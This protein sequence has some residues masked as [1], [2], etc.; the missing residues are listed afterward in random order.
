MGL[1]NIF[2]LLDVSR[3][4]DSYSSLL[5]HLLRHSSRLR[6]QVL[7]H[8]FGTAVP[9]LADALVA[10]RATLPDNAG[11]ADLLIVGHDAE[12]QRWELFIE[13]K[14]DAGEGS[15]QTARYRD[16][17]RKRT[18]G[19]AAG[20]YLTLDGHAA[21]ADEGVAALRH[22]DLGAWINAALVEFADPVL[23]MAAEAY[24][25]RVCIASPQA[26]GTDLAGELLA[27]PAGLLPWNAGIEALGTAIVASAGSGWS[28][29][30]IWIQG[31]GHAN[32]GLQFHRTGWIGTPIAGDRFERN[33][34]NVHAEIEL[35]G[36]SPWR[37]KIHFETEPYRTGGELGMLSNLADYEAMR[38]SFRK[39]VHERAADLPGWK[40]TNYRLQMCAFET[41]VGAEST[42]G[43]VVAV[44]AAALTTV[45]SIVDTALGVA[46]G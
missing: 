2:D 29:A 33:N 39:A 34:H 18:G 21:E 16:A 14:I 28:Y 13:N 1:L 27:P 36:D 3:R 44:L 30:S 35:V 17:C 5:C 6:Q 32:P 41:D 4:E 22:D 46:K 9:T 10:F 45:G 26:T 23:R 24:V 8:G 11:V 12:G 37:L 15:D 19:R 20:I 38:E 40:M 31:P 43:E 25:G 42:V 7:A